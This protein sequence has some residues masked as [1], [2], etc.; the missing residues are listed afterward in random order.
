MP[1]LVHLAVR[2]WGHSTA[3]SM[4]GFAFETYNEPRQARWE[5]GADKVRVAFKSEGFARDCYTG[6]LQ[7][8]WVRERGG[9][10]AGEMEGWE[11]CK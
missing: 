3:V 9:S 6:V 10:A 2:A 7:V 5:E 11:C 8:R 4:A 1:E